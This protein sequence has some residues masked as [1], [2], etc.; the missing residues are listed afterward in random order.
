M[1]ASIVMHNIRKILKYGVIP[2]APKLL[3]LQKQKSPGRPIRF[4]TQDDK[5]FVGRFLKLSKL[6]PIR[7]RGWM[8]A[9]HN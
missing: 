7:W 8:P 6:Q 2:R 1:A 9:G 5:H 3:E 4:C